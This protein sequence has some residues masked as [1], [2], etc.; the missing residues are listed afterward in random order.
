[1]TTDTMQPTLPK[2]QVVRYRGE[3]VHVAGVLVSPRA[4]SKL[5]WFLEQPGC[6]GPHELEIVTGH[7]EVIR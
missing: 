2:G 1:M 5:Y 7:P 3:I 4:A 6:V